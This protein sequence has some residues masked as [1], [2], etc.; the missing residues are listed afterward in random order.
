MR[1]ARYAHTTE[2]IRYLP[3]IDESKQSS[4]FEM[5]NVCEAK[6]STNLKKNNGK[7]YRLSIGI[8]EFPCNITSHFSNGTMYGGRELLMHIG[9]STEYNEDCEGHNIEVQNF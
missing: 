3:L 9:V 4:L 5:S 6:N 8:E 1:Q 7:N 2:E